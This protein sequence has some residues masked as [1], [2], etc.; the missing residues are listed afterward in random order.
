M[1]SSADRHPGDQSSDAHHHPEGISKDEARL[2]TSGE[3]GEEGDNA[4]S[5]TI[6]EAI[7]GS[8]ITAF[9]QEPTKRQRRFDKDRV[10]QLVKVPLVEQKLVER[11]K[12]GCSAL[13]QA[14]IPD[15]EPQCHKKTARHRN[16]G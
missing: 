10:V 3:T 8:T 2:R 11:F 13:G 16:K 14:W 5:K 12:R 6:K 7:N 9:P 15:V 4:H 1:R